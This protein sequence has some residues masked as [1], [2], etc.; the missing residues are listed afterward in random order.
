VQRNG[1]I[2]APDVNI[3]ALVTEIHANPAIMFALKISMATNEYIVVKRAIKLFNINVDMCAECSKCERKKHI[4]HRRAHIIRKG[5][6]ITEIWSQPRESDAIMSPQRKIDED[7]NADGVIM[8]PIVDHGDTSLNTMAPMP[9]TSS[10]M[11]RAVTDCVAHAKKKHRGKT[12]TVSNPA[13]LSHLARIREKILRDDEL[14]SPDDDIDAIMTTI[15]N[16][17]EIMVILEITQKSREYVIMKRLIKLLDMENEITCAECPKS[18][19]EKRRRVR[20]LRP[21]SPAATH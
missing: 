2:L 15:R 21:R 3:A 17:P 7:H 13:I 8:H 11:I 18:P 1:E 14:I 19:M 9:A 12:K 10:Q 16:D 20:L 5:P 4:G 6:C